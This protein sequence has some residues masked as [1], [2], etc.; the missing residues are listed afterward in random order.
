MPAENFHGFCFNAV[1]FDTSETLTRASSLLP[2]FSSFAS[3]TVFQPLAR[4]SNQPKSLCVFAHAKRSSSNQKRASRNKRVTARKKVTSEKQPPKSQPRESGA[5]ADEELH[6]EKTSGATGDASP[7][8]ATTEPSFR[9]MENPEQDPL[10]APTEP[11]LP[12]PQLTREE[13]NALRFDVKSTPDQ[14]IEYFEDARRSRDFAAI[15]VANRD[16]VTENV[17]YRFTSA[18]LQVDTRDKNM[19]SREKEARNMRRLRKELIAYC[20]RNNFV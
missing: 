3:P 17:L 18:I 14:V 20:W 5:R 6:R 1:A 9:Q 15:V 10:D 7:H 16:F 19:E 11:L 8:R 4:P 2:A 13:I 12:L